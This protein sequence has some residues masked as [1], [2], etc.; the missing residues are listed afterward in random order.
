MKKVSIITATYNSAKTISDTLNSIINQSYLD[1][2]LVIVDGASKDNT[3]EVINSL[4]FNTNREKVIVSESDKGLY[5]ALNKGLSLASGDIIGFLHSDDIFASDKTL[6]NIMHVF[7]SSNPDV[8]YGDIEILK[9]I[10][11]LRPKRKWISRKFDSSLLALGWMPAHTSMFVKSSLYLEF[12]VFD[13]SFSISGDYEFI[14]RIFKN[15]ELKSYYL[16]ETLIKMLHGGASTKNFRSFVLKSIEDLRAL[17]I[18]KIR[19][20]FLVLS[21]KKISKITQFNIFK[22]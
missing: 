10:D 11:D 3:L 14:L 17:K 13:T 12:G 19:F 18:N 9:N 4:L 20:P 6:Y 8:I 16:P 1:I 2:E 5:D 7:M 21:A 15:R 22:K